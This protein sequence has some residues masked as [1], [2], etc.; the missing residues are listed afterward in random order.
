MPSSTT[1][2][3]TLADSPRGEAVG[4]RVTCTRT[5]LP[6]PSPARVVTVGVTLS[7]S[8]FSRR[9]ALSGATPYARFAACLRPAE[10]ACTTVS[11]TS[12]PGAQPFSTGRS[13]TSA[14]AFVSENTCEYTAPSRS[15][16]SHATP[17]NGALT[18]R[19]GTSP[20]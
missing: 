6:F 17:A 18:V 14:V 9:A 7:D 8:S 12:T 4:V 13:V 15:T 10:A 11:A 2:T 3:T 5:S 1:V 19:R 20:T 16:C